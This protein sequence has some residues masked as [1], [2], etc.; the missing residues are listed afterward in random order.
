MLSLL[1]QAA[2]LLPCGHGPGNPSHHRNP[3]EGTELGTLQARI[4]RNVR[5]LAAGG[6]VGCLAMAAV[7]VAAF[8]AAWGFVLA[9]LAL[10]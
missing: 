8:R 9:A 3:S 5:A 6:A 10:A 1:P 7:A 2:V 4:L